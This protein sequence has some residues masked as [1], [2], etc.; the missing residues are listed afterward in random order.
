MNTPYQYV[1]QYNSVYGEL[2]TEYF[3]DKEKANQFKDWLETLQ[4]QRGISNLKII[5]K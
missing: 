2:I 4:S 1:V 5:K 3:D